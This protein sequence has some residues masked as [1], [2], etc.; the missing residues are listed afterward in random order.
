V[1]A[2]REKR[3]KILYL[4]FLSVC[5]DFC[6]KFIFVCATETFLFLQKSNVKRDEEEKKI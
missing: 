2:E 6:Q 3:E 1:E 5:D 4:S